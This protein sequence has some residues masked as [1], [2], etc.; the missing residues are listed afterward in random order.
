MS[1]LPLLSIVASGTPA[2]PLPDAASDDVEVWYEPDGRTVAALGHAD[3]AE[4]WWFHMPGLASFRFRA[5]GDVVALDRRGAAEARIR[6]AYRRS[7]LPLVLQARGLEVLHASA[8]QTHRGVLALCATKETGKSTIAYALSRRGYALWADDAVAMQVEDR[9][10]RAH[11]LP[12]SIRLRPASA[13]HFGAD[14][15]AAPIVEPSVAPLAA[16]FVL[17][18]DESVAEGA[19]VRR[20][21]GG[22]ALTAI[23]THAY[24]FS[25]ADQ[26]RKGRMVE[27]YLTVTARV[28]V[29]EAR[30]GAGLERLPAI[31]DAIERAAEVGPVRE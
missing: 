15:S 14:S 18:R 17:A 9:A 22:A 20:L 24:C 8:V 25:L 23:L 12:F 29:F 19:I 31:L 30:F 16:L 11:P 13:A 27:Q 28:P 7:V 6:D 21:T 26:D 4:G 3:G 2:P 10:V 5:T 1:T